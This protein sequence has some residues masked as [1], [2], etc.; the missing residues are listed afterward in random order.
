MGAHVSVAAS[1]PLEMVQALAISLSGHVLVRTL[2]SW[3]SELV[4]G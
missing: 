1:R 4:A 3:D 2:T